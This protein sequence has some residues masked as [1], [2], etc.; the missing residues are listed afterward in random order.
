[1]IFDRLKQTR[2]TLETTNVR[3]SNHQTRQISDMRQTSDR[4]II[5]QDKH[6]TGQSSDRTIIKQDKH[7]T[8]QTSDRTNIRQD[9]HQTGQSSDRTNIKHQNKENLQRAI[10]AKRIFINM[11]DF[12]RNCNNLF[13][14]TKFIIFIYLFVYFQLV[15][16][17]E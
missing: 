5:R 9:N 12:K 17:V 3:H 6:Q 11:R 2:Q 16:I 10:L 8:G 7:Q 14:M 13:A 1:M 4:T 15:C